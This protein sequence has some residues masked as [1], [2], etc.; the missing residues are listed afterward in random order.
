MKKNERSIEL[1]EILILAGLLLAVFVLRMATLYMPLNAQEGSFAYAAQQAKTGA[2]IYVDFRDSSQPLT[3]YIYT[4]A[5]SIL[6]ADT[7]AIRNFTA[8]VALFALVIFYMLARTLL[9]RWASL[10]AALLYAVMMHQPGAG[11]FNATPPFFAH[12]PVMLAFLFLL[13]RDKGYDA[14][15]YFLCGVF[16]A[17]AFFTKAA[18]GALLLAPAMHIL[19][20]SRG[21]KE[22]WKN[23]L[24]LV[25]GFAAVEIIVFA[26]MAKAGIL[27]GY[28]IEVI[29][30]GLSQKADFTAAIRALGDFAAAAPLA[31][32]AMVWAVFKLEK[33][34]ENAVLAV[35]AGLYIAVAALFVYPAARGLLY[36]VTPLAALL[37]ALMLD[38]LYGFMSKNK[39]IKKYALYAAA[40]LFA[41]ACVWT[42]LFSKIPG[43][44]FGEKAQA[45][46][47]EAELLSA[48]INEL[49][50]GNEGLA[51]WPPMPGVHFLTKTVSP[52]RYSSARRLEALRQEYYAEI[53]DIYDTQ[54]D[55]LLLEKTQG[56]QNPLDA[57]AR[58]AY[59]SVA[60]TENLELFRK[61]NTVNEKNK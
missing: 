21:K 27:R 51:C 49:K 24:W 47:Y 8:Y 18:L 50:K 9:N 32:A 28:W 26:W 55:F 5:I 30:V 6:G 36:S 3:Y 22:W 41:V 16:V 2:K 35:C 1:R 25:A 12:V 54:P 10:A 29:G 33:K 37:I 14:V 57:L 4:A 56:S 58:Q 34:Q 59:V 61:G 31:A 23:A 15:S 19:Y 53:K 11:G 39:K 40:A 48:K 45:V 52:V 17:M 13:E 60:S 38:N 46:Y 20:F 42:G 43:Y 44:L 7:T